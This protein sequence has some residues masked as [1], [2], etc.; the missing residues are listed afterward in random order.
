MKKKSDK[1]PRLNVLQ[2]YSHAKD[3]ATA[4]SDLSEQIRQQDSSINIAFFSDEYDLDDLALNLKTHLPTPLIGCTTSG[5]LSPE[6]FQHGGITGVSLASDQLRALPY[7]I[8]PL[9]NITEQVMKIAEDIKSVMQHTPWP[10][11]GM[12][13]VDGLCSREER[14][15]AALYRSLGDVPIF[16]GSAGDMLK[17]ANT[18][19]YHDGVMYQDAAVFTLFLTTLPFHIFKH[20]H[21]QPSS[22]RLVITEADPARRIVKEI[23]GEPA[24]HAYARLINI[25][26]DQLDASVF[27]RNPLLLQFRDDYYIR[28][29]SGIEPDG[30]L[31]F[32]CAIDKGLVLSIGKGTPGTKILEEDLARIKEDIGEPAVILGCDC[33]LRRLQLEGLQLDENM[34]KFLARNKV[35]GFHTYGEQFNSVHVNQTFTGVAIAG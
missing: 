14:L 34:G 3:P 31:R 11:F 6:G 1:K 9:S 32:Y 5:Q 28:S 18:F 27:S 17:F 10:A 26:V 4:L 29:I 8:H 33:I 20:Q 25:P 13:L 22:T 2:G 35:V 24:A 30:S 16:G 12:L 23:N 21:F 15:T 7:L 19:V